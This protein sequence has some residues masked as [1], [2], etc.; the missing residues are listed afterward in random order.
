MEFEKPDKQGKMR[1][2]VSEIVTLP[3]SLLGVG[4]TTGREG[5]KARREP[6]HQ[7]K[8]ELREGVQRSQALLGLSGLMMLGAWRGPSLDSPS[9]GL[10][11]PRV[12]Q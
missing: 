3:G 6:S 8:T 9:Q 12:A 4:A 2:L 1:I 7:P 11:P 10:A 5:E